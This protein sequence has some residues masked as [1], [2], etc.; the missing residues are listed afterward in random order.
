[1]TVQP[2]TPEQKAR[3]LADPRQCVDCGGTPSAARPR[4]DDCHKKLL[5]RRTEGKW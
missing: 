2:S 1:M 3:Y 4:C 5:G